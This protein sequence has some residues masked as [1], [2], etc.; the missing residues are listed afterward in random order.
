MYEVEY[1]GEDLKKRG[2]YNEA[3][4]VYKMVY[5]NYVHHGEG[6]GITNSLIDIVATIE[7]MEDDDK[8]KKVAHQCLQTGEETLKVIDALPL[9]SNDKVVYKAQCLF[10]MCDIHLLLKEYE[11]ATLD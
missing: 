3:L 11:A 10:K 7:E 9:P 2:K 6:W 5:D 4:Y 8:R 1:V